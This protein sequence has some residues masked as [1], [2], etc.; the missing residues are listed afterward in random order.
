M[1][2]PLR[3]LTLM[4]RVPSMRI[5][6]A[7][8]VGWRGAGERVGVPV[9][10]AEGEAVVNAVDDAVATGSGVPQAAASKVTRTIRMSSLFIC[11]ILAQIK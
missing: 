6:V 2:G 11:W 7:V 1:P 10:S 5:G 3:T 9:G 8:A 4:V